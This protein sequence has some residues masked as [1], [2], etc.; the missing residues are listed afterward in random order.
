M[1]KSQ[2]SKPT[3]PTEQ[4]GRLEAAW[5]KRFA[6]WLRRLGDLSPEADAAYWEATRDWQKARDECTD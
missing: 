6:A 4:D 5:R 3:M 2:E 1:A